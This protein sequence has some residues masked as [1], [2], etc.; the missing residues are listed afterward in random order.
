MSIVSSIFKPL[1]PGLF[2]NLELQGVVKNVERS[3]PNIAGAE[4][5][6][7]KE[8]AT[9][10]GKDF[11]ISPE[12][13]DQAAAEW[14][15][16]TPEEWAAKYHPQGVNMDVPAGQAMFEIPDNAVQVLKGKDPMNP[17]QFPDNKDFGINEIIKTD[18]LNKAYPEMEDIRVRF[19]TDPEN[20][21][22][23]ATFNPKDNV[24][25]LNRASEGVQTNGVIPSM[26]HEIQHY[27]QGKELLTAGESFRIRLQDYPDFGAA[28]KSMQK[29]IGS[30]FLQE[31]AI[32][33]SK[34]IG[35]S[36]TN[37][38][39]AMSTMHANEGADT[40]VILKHMLGSKEKADE[41]IQK[42][43]KLKVI[44]G[45]LDD[46]EMAKEAFDRAF[47]DY[48]NVAGEAYARSTADRRNLT[49]GE[50]LAQPGMANLD[51]PFSTLTPSKAQAILA[52]R[53]SVVDPNASSIIDTTAQGL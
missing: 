11:G 28:D 48:T 25:T 19:I 51:V 32:K 20:P 40:K 38:M 16:L 23:N 49:M 33:L 5:Y 30:R 52:A 31:D 1:L 34:E 9:R 50:R 6:A 41:F 35:T 46:K 39:D 21:G 43:K 18:L 13:L 24:L 2:D 14:K 15:K 45:F 22:H 29:A 53:Q 36:V 7:G 10:V 27:V 8:A 12:L 26:L 3:L 42:G 47:K 37:I 44:G 4:M 17:K